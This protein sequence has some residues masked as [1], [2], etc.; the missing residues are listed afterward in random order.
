MTERTTISQTA[1]RK[2]ATSGRRSAVTATELAEH[3]GLSRQRIAALADVEHVIERL[4][5]GRFNQDGAR[6]AYIKWLRSPERRSARST[7]ASAFADAKTR[8]VMLRVREREGA[9]MRTAEALETVE[10][11]TGLFVSKLCS[12]P[13]RLSRDLAVRRAAEKIVF[14]IRTTIADEAA[15]FAAAH[16]KE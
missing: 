12:L 13:A 2:A 15:R 1:R 8:L 10:A 4:Q 7:A 16:E 14:E 11:L 5:D 6:L 3:L 9:L